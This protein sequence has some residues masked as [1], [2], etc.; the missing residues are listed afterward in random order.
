MSQSSLTEDGIKADLT[1]NLKGIDSPNMDQQAAVLK[2]KHN[3]C[4]NTMMLSQK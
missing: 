4:E 1:H 2:S 3:S